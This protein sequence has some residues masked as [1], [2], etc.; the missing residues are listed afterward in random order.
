[1]IMARAN[2]APVN[3]SSR[4]REQNDDEDWS[5]TP[6]DKRPGLR[7]SSL[8]TVYAIDIIYIALSRICLPDTIV[9][10]APLVRKR[11]WITILTCYCES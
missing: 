4:E 10:V 6:C 2:P 8:S 7:L 9:V 1:M 5:H 3:F 11:D